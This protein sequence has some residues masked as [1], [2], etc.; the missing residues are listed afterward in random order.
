M[1]NAVKPGR[2]RDSGRAPGRRLD[3]GALQRLQRGGLPRTVAVSEQA[4]DLGKADALR[5]DRHHHTRQARL[6]F[7]QLERV[8]PV[9]LRAELVGQFRQ[10]VRRRHLDRI[11]AK[12]CPK[13]GVHHKAL[14]QR[15]ELFGLLSG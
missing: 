7:A 14:D 12:L 15:S 11:P 5:R 9:A 8:N 6:R 3:P 1:G 4:A 2:L 13:R 10:A